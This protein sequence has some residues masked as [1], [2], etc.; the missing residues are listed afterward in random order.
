MKRKIFYII[1]GGVILLGI[2]TGCENK[3][4]KV[5][6]KNSNT[7][8]LE[9]STT[10]SDNWTRLDSEYTLIFNQNE[11]ESSQLKNT[12]TILSEWYPKTIEQYLDSMEYLYRGYKMEVLAMD[13]ESTTYTLKLN[14]EGI[15]KYLNTRII[16]NELSSYQEALENNDCTCIIK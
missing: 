8:T 7:S 9:C 10:K 2:T 13:K 12:M 14:K 6:K 11:L 3:V 5:T 1:L 4:N 16:G 15:E